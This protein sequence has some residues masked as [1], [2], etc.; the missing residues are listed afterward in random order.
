M[1]IMLLGSN[2]LTMWITVVIYHDGP[3]DCCADLTDHVDH[4]DLM[5]ISC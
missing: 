3:D 1:L 2:M 4:V 5:L